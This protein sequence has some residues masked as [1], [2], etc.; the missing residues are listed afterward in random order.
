M[1][2]LL[3]IFANVFGGASYLIN[4]WAL[5]E[6]STVSFLFFRY[7][8]ASVSLFPLFLLYPISLNQRLVKQ[9]IYLSLLQNHSHVWAND[10]ALNYFRFFIKLRYRLLHR[11]LV[12]HS[13][14]RY[15]ENA[16]CI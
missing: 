13:F 2:T 4:K 14:H 1:H 10:G 12:T 6:I 5:Q 11:I 3:M 8:V 15:E 9:G 7:A 16:Q